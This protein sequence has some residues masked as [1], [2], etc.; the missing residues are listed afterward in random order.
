MVPDISLAH[1]VEQK[2]AVLLLINRV[3]TI[4]KIAIHGSEILSVLGGKRN[5]K[6]V[7][8]SSQRLSIY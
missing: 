6:P 4:L 3:K 2:T 7:L 8:V 5:A 1:L